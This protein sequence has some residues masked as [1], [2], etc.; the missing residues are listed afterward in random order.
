MSRSELL[1]EYQDLSGLPIIAD[2]FKSAF[3]GQQ[4]NA[5]HSLGGFVG[6]EFVIGQDKLLVHA[7]ENPISG[8]YIFTS[9]TRF[10][11]TGLMALPDGIRHEK[12]VHIAPTPVLMNAPGCPTPV[13]VNVRESRFHFSS[14]NSYNTT[15]C[16]VMG[17]NGTPEQVP[18]QPMV[19]FSIEADRDRS[20]HIATAL[21]P[22]QIVTLT[23]STPALPPG[24]EV[25]FSHI[26]EALNWVY[27]D[28]ASSCDVSALIVPRITTDPDPTNALLP[29][30]VLGNILGP[31]GL[32]DFILYAGT[33][34][35]LFQSLPGTRNYGSQIYQALEKETKLGQKELLAQCKEMQANLFTV[36]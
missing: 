5:E 3:V 36:I 30:E 22:D 32:D 19:G 4:L 18:M 20:L 23:G 9:P 17:S 15:T 33:G 14:P 28:G 21:T 24:Y 2:G 34:T 13:I 8:N 26:G 27:T 7:L 16:M 35:N 11:S 25:L 12:A 1:A 10:G 6:A 29:L 31:Q